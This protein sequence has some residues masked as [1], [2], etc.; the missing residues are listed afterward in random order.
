MD[1]QKINLKTLKAIIFDIAAN[2]NAAFLEIEKKHNIEREVFKEHILFLDSLEL[3]EQQNIVIMLSE[4]EEL[5]PI[6]FKQHVETL[7]KIT[8]VLDNKEL[9]MF[10]RTKFYKDNV[11]DYRTNLVNSLKE[12]NLL[13]LPDA[14]YLDYALKNSPSCV[15][16]FLVDNDINTLDAFYQRCITS[17]TEKLTDRKKMEL[18]QKCHMYIIWE[19]V[20]F[21]KIQDDKKNNHLVE[22]VPYYNGYLPIAKK[23]FEKIIELYRMVEQEPPEE[24][25]KFKK[26][27]RSLISDKLSIFAYFQI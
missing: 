16:H 19:N 20:I 27:L 15:R 4:G 3:L 1:I 10:M 22:P 9:S 6:R 18:I 13:P 26:Y 7:Q 17:N 14:E 21:G 25:S 8:R 2:E 24:K 11:A 12:R 23:S 5:L